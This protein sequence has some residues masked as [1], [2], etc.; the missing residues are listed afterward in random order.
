M[1]KSYKIAAYLLIMLGMIHA[2]FT[3]LFFKTFNAEAL[4]FFGIGLTY[5]FMGLYNLAS[6]KVQIKSISF[7]AIVLNFIATVFTIA[8]A[9]ILK[10][11]Q[12][13]VAL[14]LVIFIFIS[15]LILRK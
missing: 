9:Y 5:I 6:I 15:S 7:M 11:P 1:E 8:I 2:G 12:A 10:E 13:Y 4:W 3:L 14:V